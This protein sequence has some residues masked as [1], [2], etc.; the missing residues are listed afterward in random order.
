MYLNGNNWGMSQP[1]K[2]EEE[3]EKKRGRRREGEEEGLWGLENVEVSV[4]RGSFRE[5]VTRSQLSKRFEGEHHAKGRADQRG[6]RG[7]WR[8][9]GTGKKGRGKGR[10]KKGR[11]K[12]AEVEVAGAKRGQRAGAKGQGAKGQ[13]QEGERE[14]GSRGKRARERQQAGREALRQPRQKGGEAD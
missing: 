5:G 3:R 2:L 1:N 11:G 8:L 10:G 13:R 14:R 7:R 6:Q 9:A 4:A 12:R